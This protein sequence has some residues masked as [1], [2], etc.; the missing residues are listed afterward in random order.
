MIS[1]FLSQYYYEYYVLMLRSIDNYYS[2]FEYWYEMS[3][4]YLSMVEINSV[5]PVGNK[6]WKTKSGKFV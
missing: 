3:K 6:R 2:T 4:G 1:R 5:I